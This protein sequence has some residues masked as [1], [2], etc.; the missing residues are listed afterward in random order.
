MAFGKLTVIAGPM[1]AGKTED[2]V[3]EI[4]YRQYF[5]DK[6]GGAVGIFFPA[7][8]TRY[9]EKHIVTHDGHAVLARA[10]GT[11]REIFDTELR[12]A[13]FDEV[14]FFTSPQFDGDFIEV[15]RDLR[16]DGVDVT[17][18]GLDMDYLGRGFEITAALMSE[19]SEIRRHTAHCS[20]CNAPATHTTRCTEAGGRFLL[21]A[22]KEYSA[23]C[24]EHWFR[25]LS[26]GQ[27]GAQS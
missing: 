15:V 10:A 7:F 13:F 21:G 11:E 6:S 3:K 23:M 14:Q 17:C 26:K 9:G 2:L 19:A 22:D 4:L 18:A 27:K 5:P 20:V 8:D 12:Y 1:Y 25:S 24:A 16:K